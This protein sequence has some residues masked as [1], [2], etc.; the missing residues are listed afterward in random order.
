MLIQRKRNI[1]KNYLHVPGDGVECESFTIISI[2]SLLVYGE[3]HYPQV[4]LVTCSY[5]ILNTKMIDHLND[6]HFK[7]DKSQFF[8]FDELVSEMMY[9]SKIK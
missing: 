7:S 9:Y 4:Y 3:K 6:N 2:D 5:R 1:L 8:G